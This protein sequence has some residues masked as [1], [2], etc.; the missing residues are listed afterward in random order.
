MRCALLLGSIALLV[1]CDDEPVIP[2]T[3]A[4]R[5]SSPDTAVAGG[6]LQWQ[7]LSPISAFCPSDETTAFTC[8]T[9]IDRRLSVCIEGNKA[10][11]RY[12][13]DSGQLVL[14]GGRFAQR[15]Y[16][17]GGEAQIKFSN[18]AWDYVVFSR[19]VRTN[20]EPG[21]PNN[22]AISDGVI[23][24]EGGK[25]RELIEC[26][27]SDAA[28]VPVDVDLLSRPLPRDAELYTE[29]T[30]RADSSK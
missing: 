27:P 14:G 28:M 30:H 29:E 9:G 11:Y 24:I 23:V 12:R 21:E 10:S 5:A 8:R 22:P 17:G 20:F 13:G 18:G 16:S 3:E 26:D 4:N 19:M 15:A 2:R 6:E 25:F 1:A 7:P